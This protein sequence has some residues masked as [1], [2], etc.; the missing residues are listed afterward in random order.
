MFH[1]IILLI[2]ILA[3]S[4]LYD[5]IFYNEWFVDHPGRVISPPRQLQVSTFG[6]GPDKLQVGIVQYTDSAELV[7][8][9]IREVCQRKIGRNAG[10]IHG[11]FYISDTSFEFL[12]MGSVQNWGWS[13]SMKHS[14]KRSTLPFTK[15]LGQEVNSQHER[16]GDLRRKCILLK[17]FVDSF[18]T[19]Q[20]VSFIWVF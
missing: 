8:Q 16:H 17:L 9:T 13:G 20:I 5:G 12:F 1:D 18:L 3:Y 11:D 4:I 19:C 7:T 14:M 6:F 15:F 2:D 10:K